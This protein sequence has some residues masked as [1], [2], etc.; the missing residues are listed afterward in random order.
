MKKVS[1]MMSMLLMTLAWTSCD[2][3]DEVL[4]APPRLK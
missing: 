4:V 3:E 1:V 2:D